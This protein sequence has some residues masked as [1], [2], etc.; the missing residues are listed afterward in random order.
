[1][2]IDGIFNNLG[3]MMVVHRTTGQDTDAGRTAS[4][5]EQTQAADG[6]LARLTDSASLSA[7]NPK[8]R[9]TLEDISERG[10][11]VLETLEQNVADLQEGFLDTLSDRLEA[12]GVSLDE[13]LTLSMDDEGTLT[14]LGDHPDK[15]RIEKTL[16]DAPE[17]SSAFGELASQSE[18][19]RDIRSLRRVVTTRVGAAAYDAV[20]AATTDTAET[21][22]SAYRVSLKGAM[23]HFY[24]GR[25]A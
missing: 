18:L 11:N 21:A 16:T 12:A 13:K 19:I 20:D 24:F 3:S 1:M 10:G 17:L 2:A 6:N 14:V 7:L 4:G 5:S 9:S 23:S 8:L 15:A 25:N 22:S